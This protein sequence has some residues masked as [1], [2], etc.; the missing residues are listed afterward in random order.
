VFKLIRNGTVFAPEPLGNVDVLL[1]GERIGL[2]GRNLPIPAPAA[3]ATEVIEAAGRYVLPGLI[4]GHVHICGG[5]GEGGYHTRTPEIT[6]SSLV[7]GGIT[8]VVGCLGTDGVTRTFE[9]LYA[10]A[11]GLT[12]EGI[13]A[14]V[15]TGSYRLPIATFS[16]DPMKDIMFLDLVVGAGEVALADHRSSQPGLEDL[17]RLAA[18]IRVGAML[19]GKAGVINV[20]LGDGE[21]GLAMLE[22]LVATTEIPFSQFLPTHVNRC[23]RVFEE[24]IAYA[25]KGGFIDLTAGPGDADHPLDGYQALQR[26]LERGVPPER[27]S[28]T[29][30]GQGS[31]PVFN[32]RAELVR[33]EV[34]KVTSL[35]DEVRDAVRLAGLDLETVLATVTRN[36][37][38]RY[39][40]K[41]KG[42]LRP[43]ADADV[44]LVDPDSFEVRTVIARGRVLMREGELEVRGT[45]E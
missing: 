5:G 43:G 45:F 30:D 32:E 44:I 13:T 7:R 1:V 29:S 37:A 17:R 31:L 3:L 21:G 34:G 42:R 33:L 35:F 18:A 36:P 23:E 10:K 28:L 22:T 27:V 9:G 26:C 4:D 20:H 19:S 38:D 25:G 39:Q 24:G 8:T 14:F 16:G 40:L 12:E 2:I 6:L 41:G 11:K 15:L